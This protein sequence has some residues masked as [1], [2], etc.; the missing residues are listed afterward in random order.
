MATLNDT[1]FNGTNLIYNSTAHSTY[2]ITTL[3][4]LSWVIGLLNMLL[5]PSALIMNI[6][7]LVV[8]GRHVKRKPTVYFLRNL[9]AS[10]LLIPVAMCLIILGRIDHGCVGFM[11]VHFFMYL[12]AVT[13][14][15]VIALVA[16][17]LLRLV[18][19][20]REI[21]T[22]LVLGL[23]LLVL[24][25]LPVV[26]VYVIP[27]VYYYVEY[28][29]FEDSA[30]YDTKF[31]DYLSRGSI[32][33]NKAVVRVWVAYCFV[34]LAAIF[35][36]YISIYVMI[37]RMLHIQSTGEAGS[38]VHKE[39]ESRETQTRNEMLKLTVMLL[40]CLIVFWGPL[41]VAWIILSNINVYGEGI[42]Y[43]FLWQVISLFTLLNP[44]MDP[45]IVLLR[46]SDVKKGF[47]VV[48]CCCCLRCKKQRRGNLQEH[49]VTYTR[50]MH[51]QMDEPDM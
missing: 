31:C 8:Y 24:W 28:S 39:E 37:R 7:A 9:A 33:F 22:K 34:C 51:T 20:G 18:Y 50:T 21:F 48:C 26:V 25:T 29:N 41:L 44:I 11:F 27:L 38:R 1:L 47:H 49:S 15:A 10:D 23:S 32:F 5:L 36:I 6:I 17:Q 42:N 40:I 30:K 13:I 16:E 3:H 46:M 2:Q 14:N 4:Y 45:I 12:G 35:A 19:P 43:Y